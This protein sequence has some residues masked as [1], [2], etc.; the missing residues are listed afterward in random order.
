MTSEEMQ[1]KLLRH[2]L[3]HLYNPVELS[4]ST[5]ISEFDLPVGEEPSA[6]IRHIF[7]EAIQA[8]K[9]TIGVSQSTQVWRIYHILVF[10]FLEQSSQKQVASELGL[11][12]RQVSRLEKLA[13]QALSERL[14][15][16]QKRPSQPELADLLEKLPN[17]QPSFTSQEM[18]LLKMTFP[19]EIIETIPFIE[20]I[21]HT[22]G[23]LAESLNV[24]MNYHH[25]G[26]LPAIYG[27]LNPIRQGV[28][29]ALTSI[30][31]SIPGGEIRIKVESVDQDILLE[32]SAIPPEGLA[33][34]S[35]EQL[36]DGCQQAL[37]LIELSGGK[38]KID[39]HPHDQA[40]L[41][42]SLYLPMTR[43]RLVLALDDNQDALRLI[44]RFL[45]GSQYRLFGLQDPSALINLSENLHPD[46]ILLDVMLPEV[47]GWELLGRL[48]E[49]PRLSKIPV[50]VSS[51][52][53]QEPLAMALGAA[54]FLRK[55]V[56][57]EELLQTLD[58]LL[59]NSKGPVLK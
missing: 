43:T 3:R 37:S 7:I 41:V 4:R 26:T 18:E 57:Q 2:A 12:I 17:S 21:L 1:I 35:G 59:L 6:A 11:S 39:S 51:I 53:S 9:P 8:L 31:Q 33:F 36:C 16:F 40:R 22:T 23:P 5:L 42:L 24:S 20:N 48:R 54:A 19:S 29:N 45:T 55:P 52:L 34:E 56:S 44:E 25:L 27:L 13:L 58:G 28:I 38:M 10:R 49:H 15:A 32:L 46:L 30:M 14:A 50:I 47:D